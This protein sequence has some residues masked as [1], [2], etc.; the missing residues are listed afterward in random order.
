MHGRGVC[1]KGH[2][3]RGACM[4]GGMRGG[5]GLVWQLWGEG[6]CVAVGDGGTGVVRA[7]E[8]ATEAGGTHPTGMHTFNLMF[9][10]FDRS[11]LCGGQTVR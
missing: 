9:Y 3:L 11:S 6:A 1:C 4:A 5:G 8:T 10:C 2:A 7:G